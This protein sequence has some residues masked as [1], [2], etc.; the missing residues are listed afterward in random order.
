MWV[1]L[2][3]AMLSIV[4]DRDDDKRL[5]VR[6]RLAGDLETVFGDLVPTLDVVETLAADYRYRA[7]ISRDTVAAALEREVRSID[8]DNF[9]DSV[10]DA[11]R[12]RAYLQVWGCM[13]RA[14]HRAHVPADVEGDWRATLDHDFLPGPF[15][16]RDEEEERET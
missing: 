5:L 8:Y 6:A 9:K 12:H 11:D 3:D 2:S 10:E 7:S 1:F 15:T 4:E 16:I 13:W 14:Q